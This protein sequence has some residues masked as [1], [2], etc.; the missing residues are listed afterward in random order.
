GL[1]L[2]CNGNGVPD[3]CDITA[4]T[5]RDCN[6]NARPDSC[7]I[8]SGAALDCNTNGVPDA[9]DIATGSAPDCN[10][11]G[12]PDTCDVALGAPDCNQDGVPDTCQSDCNANGIADVC[13]VTS[14]TDCNG[15]GVPDT[16]ELASGTLTDRNNDGVPDS[17]QQLDFTG[18]EVELKPIVGT[19]NGLPSTAVC[20]RVYAK[21]SSPAAS[22]SGLFGDS[23]DMLAISAVGGFF[24]S[25]S[26]GN[27]AS[28]IPCST[29]DASVAFDSFLTLGG[30]CAADAPVNSVGIDYSAFVTGGAISLLDPSVGGILYAIPGIQPDASGRVLLMQLTTNTGV[31][32]NAIFNLIGDNGVKGA[33]NEWYAFGLSIP[34]P[35]LVDCNANGT[36]D[37]VEIASGLARDC[38]RSG[39]P[40]SCEFSAAIANADCDGDGAFD[41]CE[42][43]AGTEADLNNNGIA[44]DC[45]CLGDV[46]GNGAVNVDDLIEIIAAWG[47][48]NPGSAD[49]D[50]DGVVGA[51]DLTIVLQGWGSCI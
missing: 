48:P 51:A 17:C 36:H 34:D 22:V 50:G 5:A 10:S 49:L 35:V 21:L 20:W 45:E 14:A 33:D 28:E 6:G 43:Y 24:Q 16:C 27:E 19:I 4:G 46:D 38:N 47:D 37:A 23:A 15:N 30:E 7:D 29:A 1:A 18:L 11:N 31:K 39:V 42:I 32:P 41:L 44:D 13:E 40:D 9:C 25:A 3:S 2:D 26:G 8:A 12:R